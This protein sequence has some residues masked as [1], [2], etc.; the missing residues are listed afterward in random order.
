MKQAVTTRMFL[1]V[2]IL[3]GSLFQG[4]ASA[5]CWVEDGTF[6]AKKK[7]DITAFAIYMDQ[8]KKDDALRMVNDGRIK[9]CTQASA[10]VLER[11]DPVV[12]VQIMGIG[13]VWVYETQL[14]CR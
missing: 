11:D 14:H 2:L 4:W 13:K 6:Y 3:L 7:L 8:R 1:M 9:S 10:I 12:Y 5:G